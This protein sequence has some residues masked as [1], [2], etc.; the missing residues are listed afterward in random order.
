MKNYFKDIKLC[1]CLTALIGSA[2]LSFG[3]YNIHSIAD[4]TE[5]GTLG[6][7][8]LLENWFGISP[9]VT[10]ILLNTACFILGIKTLGKN[11]LIYSVVSTAGFS[12][13]YRICE[14][15]PR[16]YPEIADFPLLAAI[17]GAIFV[18]IGVGL[19]VRIGGAPS[20]DDALAMSIE[21][22]TKLKIQWV[23]LI[24]DL[25]VLL[26][27]LTYIPIKQILYSFITVVISGQI[28]G[29]ISKKSGS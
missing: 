28:I 10:S 1:S 7:T 5:G 13:S 26:L 15:F 29:I 9:S 21:K 18:G 25:T 12:V 11:F 19:C 16:I 6:L 23:Y 2:V 4:I 8:L 14:L 20:G 24:S 3:M 27:S 17:L 22:I